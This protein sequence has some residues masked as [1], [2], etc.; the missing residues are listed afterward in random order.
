MSGGVEATRH[1]NMPP[2][3]IDYL[4]ALGIDA[5]SKPYQYMTAPYRYSDSGEHRLGYVLFSSESLCNKR[6]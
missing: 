2:A 6:L 4:K 1:D 5:Q 3:Q